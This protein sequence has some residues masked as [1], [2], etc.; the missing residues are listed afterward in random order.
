[1][2]LQTNFCLITPDRNDRPEFTA[3][4][5]FQMEKQTIKP[6]NHF[7]INYKPKD[8]KPDLIT[9]IRAGVELAKRAGYEI[10]FIIENDDYYPD[11]YLENMIEAFNTSPEIEA[12]GWFETLYYHIGAQKYKLHKHPERASLFCTAFKI[13]ALEG[14]KWP[15]STEVFL[16]LVLWSHFK[17]YA[18][19]TQQ[20]N[21]PIPIGIK[22]G[23]GLCGGNGHNSELPYYTESDPSFIK[24]A[25]M[26]RN[27]SFQFYKSIVN[28]QLSINNQ[29]SCTTNKK[30][31]AKA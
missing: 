20:N 8:D 26:V 28:N 14:F 29:K 3:H 15:E 2:D 10:V 12:V 23:L 21:K 24:L 16:D 30:H 1:M 6:G 25:E 4:C 17:R 13:S 7:L 27:E 31:F 5:L 22:H 11:T 9:R 18:L 19:L